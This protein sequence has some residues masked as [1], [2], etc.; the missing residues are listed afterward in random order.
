[1]RRFYCFIL[2]LL[3]QKN[4]RSQVL[5]YQAQQVVLFEHANYTGQSKSFGPGQYVLNDFNDVTSSIR[6]PAGMVAYIYEHATPTQ[7]YGISVDLLENVADLSVYNFN[8]KVS[9]LTVFYASK[10]NKY[11]WIRNKMVNGQFVSGHWERKRAA[12]I[13][14]NSVAVV[15]PPIAGPQSTA[16]SVLAVNGPNTTINSLG[17][18]TT[19]GRMLWDK[20]MNDQLGVIGN[21]YRGI[22][23]IG[24]AA[25]E[26]A[27]YNTFIPDNF[28]FWY[29]Q[30]Q[31]ND[32]R[33]VVYYKR[34]LTGKVKSAR[35]VNIAG[36]YQDY[37]VNIDIIPNP[38]YM[39]LIN[40][41][42]RREYTGLMSSQWTLSAHQ[43]G[44]PDC[45]SPGDIEAFTRVECEIA[46]DYWPQGDH[47]F[48][49]AR[50][51]DIALN[52]TGG[53]MCAYGPWIYDAGHC[54][55]PEIHPCEQLWW[56]QPQDNGKK[57]NLNVICDASRRF[58]WRKQM[59][60]GT[61]LKPWAEPPIKGL[62]AIAFEYNLSDRDVTNQYNT[63]QFEVT[64]LHHYNVI[65]YP[66]ADQTY[67]L[68]YGGKN[69]IS[70]IPHNNAFKVSFEH[71]GISAAEPNKIRGFLVIETSV[72]MTTQ[73]ATS[74]NV[75]NLTGGG[76]TVVKLP[77]NSR[78]EQ[79]PQ[80]VEDRFFKKESGYYYFT[81][82]EKSVRSGGAVLD[83]FDGP[84]R[85]G[86]N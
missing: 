33:S 21:D 43:S 29:P 12:P 14:P 24:S 17:V 70:F 8:D 4:L 80:L 7:G 68:V 42:H 75:A 47:T 27:S 5:V 71:V 59:D 79:S 53:E 49:R 65:E 11:D 52:R 78:P 61:K 9:Y 86:G 54:C 84:V 77:A 62:F 25:F 32:H 58:L 63:K 35:Q 3:L 76:F 31:P 41:G 74:I 81:V 40:D 46:E 22:E 2:M 69:I 19:E 37:D 6:V 39:Y 34:T 66:N 57:Y 48:G 1:M 20:A 83:R 55:Q 13:P 82:N 15:S 38:K 26:R 64:N 50:L 51:T 56:S 28:N 16:P 73:V 45:D 85:R 30:K 60:D 36:T 18:Q 10:D 67:N 23:E 44:K 72:G